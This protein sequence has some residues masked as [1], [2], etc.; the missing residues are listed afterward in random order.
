MSVR[1]ADGE[2]QIQLTPSLWLSDLKSKIWIP[3]ENEKDVT[4]HIASPEL[5]RGLLNPSWLD[6][7]ASGP[8]LLVRHFGFDALD[9]RLLA[10]SSDEG[11]RQRLRDSL[12]RIVEV[13]GDNAHVIE[14][15]LVKV[16]QQ[17]RDAGM[18]TEC[19]NWVSQCRNA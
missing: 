12:A 15:L 16:Q 2:K 9:V 4:H 14:E 19:G 8:D 18:W 17:S 5:V 10:V 7:N 11:T 3:V 13:V 6:G 1:T